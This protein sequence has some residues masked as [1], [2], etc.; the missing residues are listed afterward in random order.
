MSSQKCYTIRWKD[1]AIELRAAAMT[2]R[3]W[4]SLCGV[5]R[6]HGLTRV[7]G[8]G[9]MTDDG[10]K[11]LGKLKDQITRLDLD[12]CPQ[13]SDD[14]LKQLANFPKLRHL[15]IGGSK[16]ILTDRG[17]EVLAEL[18]ELRQFQICWQQK[19]SDKGLAHLKHSERLERVNLMGTPSGNG[20]V[21]TLTG[22]TALT[23]LTTGTRVTDA[24]L[25]HLHQFP[26]FKQWQNRERKYGLM[27][28]G[29]EP[30]QLVLDG[31][32][33]DQGLASLAGLDGLFG[34]SFFWHCPKFTSAGLAI[35]SRLANLGA[36]GCQDAHC[37]DVALG[38]IAAVPNLRM[39]MAQGAVATE[40]GFAALAKSKTLEYVWG[41]DWLNFGNRGF[42]AFAKMRSLKGLA[43][44]LRNVDNRTVSKL[45]SF[46]A[47]RELTPMDVS[48]EAFLPVGQCAQLEKLWCMY[49]RQTGDV[50]TGHLKGLTKLKS[51]YAGATQISDKSLKILARM[52]SLEHLEFRQC[53]QIT[54]SGAAHLARLPRLREIEFGGDPGISREACE[55]IFPARVA[56]THWP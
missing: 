17:L 15:D 22:K 26:V 32:F 25:K 28:A 2:N 41:R 10:L 19:I 23:H 16:G 49:C 13:L 18:Q 36:V 11:H 34:L 38:H 46:P 33:T 21:K 5:M 56:V 12:G 40:V 44:S 51:Y 20:A 29:C 53:L 55:T 24:G 30:N 43:V 52:K 3:D 50:A 45:P 9:R 6:E 39:L 35:L 48:D 47:L 7:N 42:L 8:G 4:S 27:G 31:P 14:G 54:D 1:R 37:D